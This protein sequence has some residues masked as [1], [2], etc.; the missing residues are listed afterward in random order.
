MIISHKI[1]YSEYEY[2]KKGDLLNYSD[3]KGEI[4]DNRKSEHT[5]VE[6]FEKLDY[7]FEIKK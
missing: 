4:K 1:I 3:S 5:I 2:N 7:E 6:L